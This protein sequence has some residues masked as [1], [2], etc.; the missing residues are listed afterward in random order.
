M[1]TLPSETVFP[2]HPGVRPMTPP[3][4]DPSSKRSML[5]RILGRN[6]GTED[7]TT[8]ED[9]EASRAYTDSEPTSFTPRRAN[10]QDM[11]DGLTSEELNNLRRGAAPSDRSTA[12]TGEWIETSGKSRRRDLHD[13]S[14]YAPPTTSGGTGY[15]RDPNSGRTTTQ[16]PLGRSEFSDPSSIPIPTSVPTVPTSVPSSVSL[17]TS[18]SVNPPSVP[19]IVDDMSGAN[20]DIR[21]KR[22]NDGS[23][24]YDIKVAPLTGKTVVC[25]P[26][27]DLSCALEVTVTENSTGG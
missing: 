8:E 16:N 14:D 21:F 22:G 27:G 13:F 26:L 12:P 17:P 6:R 7:S 5:D 24:V 11:R 23:Y 19:T 18:A 25:R 15:W 2:S 3:A 1:S 20:G 10:L 4:S 9:T